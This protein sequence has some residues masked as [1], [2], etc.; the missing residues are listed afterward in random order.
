[1]SKDKQAPK[2]A[3]KEAKDAKK[4]CDST[5]QANDGAA[6]SGKG[7]ML[8]FAGVALVLGLGFG[9]G[10]AAFYFM[11]MV[12]P[13]DAHAQ[14]AKKEEEDSQA[15]PIYV[16]IDRLTVPLLE[17][18]GTI[19][20]FLSL[21]MTLEVKEKNADFVKNRQPMIRHAINE[22]LSTTSI[23]APGKSASIDYPKAGQLLKDAANKALG[24]PMIERVDIVSALP[25]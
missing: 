23:R 13:A 11:K 2:E 20:G 19:N 15:P 16:E 5:Q 21:D 14:A 3:K 10:G 22:L 24:E 7:K 6:K 8:L 17:P 4:Q 12:P 1:M 9:G 25:V 18:D